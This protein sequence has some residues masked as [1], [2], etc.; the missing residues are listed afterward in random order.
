MVPQITKALIIRL[1]SVGD[2]ILASLLVRAFRRRFPAC[3]LDFVVK[4]A[5]SELVRFNP[6]ITNVLTFPDRG[7]RAELLQL[8]TMI[9]ETGYD[10]IVDIH[11]SI[12]SRVVTFGH[13]KTV[14]MNKR[15]I[16]RFLLVRT[17]FNLY[18]FLGGSPAVS[19]RYLETV[20]PFGVTDDG[21]GLEVHIPQDVMTRAGS[22]LGGA[23]GPFIGVAP[24]SI[25]GNKMWLPERFALTALTLANE[26]HAGVILFGGGRER[27]RCDAIEGLIHEQQPGLP[28]FNTA[29]KTALLE[30][31]A[32]MDR[33]IL[34]ITNDS[35][36]M[37][38][39]A[40]R[41]R[42]V[43]ALFG[44]T[45]SEFGFFP[46][47]TNS[48]VVEHPSLTCRPCTHIGLEECPKG[49]FRCMKEIETDTVL[50]AARELVES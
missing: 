21:Q 12:R 26:N 15:K 47:G 25:H 28:V 18:P 40:A 8:R 1:S 3:R 5:C 33:C 30:A 50:A 45:V 29:A 4:D 43:I 10:L 22:F 35:G 24:G 23:N 38:L 37:H 31:A 34:V 49:H 32:L 19:D 2:V 14:R 17:G 20:R 39:A 36:L 6:H 16:A 46:T 7:S 9:C 11:D 13:P 42:P 27:E 41:K 44:P 48:R